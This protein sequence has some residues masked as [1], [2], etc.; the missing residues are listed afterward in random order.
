LN[1]PWFSKHPT[2]SL[3]FKSRLC[4]SLKGRNKDALRTQSPKLWSLA[5]PRESWITRLVVLSHSIPSHPQQSAI[6]SWLTIQS[7]NCH[8]TLFGSIKALISKRPILSSSRHPWQWPYHWPT[9]VNNVSNIQAHIFFIIVLDNSTKHYDRILLIVMCIGATKEVLL[10]LHFGTYSSCIQL[11]FLC[12]AVNDGCI[13]G[14]TL[15]SHNL[16]AFK[17]I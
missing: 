13:V 4:N 14:E 11:N 12:W 1:Q 5:P 3:A 17:N 9:E 15:K 2:N 10:I 7:L 6:S 8:W 16:A